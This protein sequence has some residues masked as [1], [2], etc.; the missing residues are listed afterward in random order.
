VDS[1]TAAEIGYAFAR[2]IPIVGYR[3][4]LRLGGDND[5]AIVNLQVE[6]FVRASGGTI[7]TRLPEI[8]GALRRISARR[9]RPTRARSSSTRTP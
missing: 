8:T 5:G 1:G 4:D 3:G 7:V 6:Y 9:A 2:G